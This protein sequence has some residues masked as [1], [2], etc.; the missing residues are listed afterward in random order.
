M[1]TSFFQRATNTYR[2]YLGQVT[3]AAP[4]AFMRMVF[5]ML[6][7]FGAVRFVALGWVEEQYIKPIVH[8]G[9]TG[10]E[11]VGSVGYPGMYIV[12]ALM[13]ASAIG[14][15]LGAWYRASSISFFL[16]F[17]YVELIDKT[18]YLN[19]YYF[20]SLVAFLF[21]LLPAHRVFSVDSLRKRWTLNATVPRWTVDV[22]KVQICMVYFF[23]GIAK[24]QPDWLFNALPLRIW[25][26][27]HDS[28][29]LIG[30][31]FALPATAWI[32]SWMGMVFDIS[33]PFLLWNKRTKW[34][35]YAAVI[36][37]HT[38]TGL[39]FQ[40]G[41]F[42]LVMIGMTLVFLIP[43]NFFRTEHRALAGS[44]KTIQTSAWI[45]PLLTVFF[46]AQILIP[47]RFLL[48]N[49]DLYWNEEG[50]RFSWRVMLMEK[51]G[52]ATF[53]VTDSMTGTSG[54]V[55]NREFLNSHQEKQM[56]FQPDMVVQ[57]ARWL[58]KHY[59][60][61]GV[62]EPVVTAD[63]WVTL[64]GRPS[65]LLVNPTTNLAAEEV[66]WHQYAWVLPNE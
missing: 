8:F 63:V 22:L 13:I 21:C 4:L 47:F 37:F 16:L 59:Q 29:P 32:F 34:Y 42:P 18:Y 6:M 36:G 61:L 38:V 3:S 53:T 10:F 2:Y 41:V 43:Q 45:T 27:A 54:I 35:A 20:V 1:A 66:G 56:S 15:M 55:D 60:E 57:Y 33:M 52:A 23:A 25:L 46:V 9:Y 17:T 30:W 19:H 24:L 31:L 58:K 14:V 48:Y 65:R 39:L 28:L 64:N 44:V 5:G 49:G 7:V 40:I 50:Y 26:P 12:F 62:K 51:S 11:W